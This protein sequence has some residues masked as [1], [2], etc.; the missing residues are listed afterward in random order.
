MS[1][2]TIAQI[3]A[4]ADT[5]VVATL[6][7]HAFTLK[8]LQEAFCRVCNEWN[9][10]LPIDK[11]VEVASARERIA[12]HLAV[13]F[14]TASVPTAE[15]IKVENGVGTFRFRAEGYYRTVGA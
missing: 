15:H 1:Q 7:E 3:L 2:P 13:R 5:Q 8:D 6:G 14:F 4:H 9:W 11:T 10:K 12:I